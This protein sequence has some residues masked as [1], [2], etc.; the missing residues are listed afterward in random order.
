MKEK[1]IRNWTTLETDTHD[2]KVNEFL[3][4]EKPLAHSRDRLYSRPEPL[5]YQDS[6]ASAAPVTKDKEAM[7]IVMKRDPS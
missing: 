4:H 7:S 3:L 6:H 1:D 2:L 5:Q